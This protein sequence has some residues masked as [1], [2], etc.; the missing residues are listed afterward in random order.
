MVD[1]VPEPSIGDAQ[2]LLNGKSHSSLVDVNARSSFTGDA[3]SMR[4]EF[5]T[6]QDAYNYYNVCARKMGFEVYKEGIKYSKKV[7]GTV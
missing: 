4:K 1:V 3:P 6:H 2:T 7:S 5:R